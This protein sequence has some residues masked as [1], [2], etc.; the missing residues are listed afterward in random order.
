MAVYHYHYHHHYHVTPQDAGQSARH[1]L[2]RPRPVRVAGGQGEAGPGEAAAGLQSPPGDLGGGRGHGGPPLQ[3]PGHRLQQPHGGQ[4]RGPRA[5]VC[6]DPLVLD[7]ND[8]ESIFLV[9]LFLHLVKHGA[10][11]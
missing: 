5:R 3:L 4:P 6:R 10:N 1:H 11:A 2:L 9:V 8:S 7:H